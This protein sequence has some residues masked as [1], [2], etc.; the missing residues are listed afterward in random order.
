MDKLTSID[1]ARLI[2]Y[3]AQKFHRQM[4]NKTQINKILFA[5]YGR[6]LA[7]HGKTLFDNEAPMAWPYGPVF[8]IV[9]K[10]VNIDEVVNFTQDKID[11]FVNNRDAQLIVVDMV[12]RMYN[13]SA[14]ALTDWSHRYGSPWYRTVYPS[15]GGHAKWNTPIPLEYIEEYFSQ[16]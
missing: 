12:A 15:D 11:M 9:N 14:Q 4:L 5:V 16:N 1:Y 7:L 8:P 10:R 2:Q 3:V 13:K 6:Y